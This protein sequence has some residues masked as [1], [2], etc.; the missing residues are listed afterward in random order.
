[1]PGYKKIRYRLTNLS[2]TIIIFLLGLLIYQNS[3]KNEFQFDDTIAINASLKFDSLYSGLPF[4][5]KIN[6]KHRPVS[7][8]ITNFNYSISGKNTISYHIFN[9][10]IH[11]IASLFV[12]LIIQLILNNSNHL[13]EDIKSKGK[14]F[15]LICALL[16]LTHPV[17]TNSVTYII[18]R[19]AS[20]AGMFYL[21]SFY[22]YLKARFRATLIQK[23]SVLYI[24]LA[25]FA[26]LA[27]LFS[28]QNAVTFP[29]AWLLGELFFVRNKQKKLNKT[30]LI[31]AGSLILIIA[32]TVIFANYL[33][34]ETDSF[35]RIEYLLTQTRV[36][37]KYI[38]LA[39]FPISLNI[40]YYFP[41]S[42][43]FSIKELI[44][45]LFLLLV[46]LSGILLYRKHRLISFGIFWFF[47]NLLVTSSII[48]IRD[49]IFEHRLYL[50][51][52]G[53]VLVLVSILSYLF[54]NLPVRYFYL[55][56]GFIILFF[57]IKTILRNVDWKTPYSLWK[58]T[59]SKSPEKARPNLNYGIA[60][61]EKKKLTEA[62]KY[63][64]KSIELD[65]SNP[66]A[67]FNRGNIRYTS[68]NYTGAIQDMKQYLKFYP[69]STASIDIAGKSYMAIKNFDSAI[70]FFNR[71][72]K[73]DSLSKR[74]FFSRGIA[75]Q[76]SGDPDR[77]L[78][79]LLTALKKDNN[80]PVILNK[81]G[82]VYFS[83]KNTIAAL[84]YY[85]K[86]IK[87]DPSFA[88]AY[89]NRAY[90]HST[91]NNINQGIKDFSRTIEINPRYAEAYK[92][93]GLLYYWKGDFINA[94]KDLNKAMSMGLKV[95][96]ALYSEIR[97]K[98]S[99]K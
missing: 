7:K 94:Y 55:I 39:F 37:S 46:L 18:Q 87:H 47:L 27:A 73:A 35:S 50:S 92:G 69:E 62:E 10:I 66:K 99:K 49:V 70:I 3:F 76:A 63:I 58:D 77:A 51:I 52:F 11:I 96:E 38:Q 71:W 34:R 64:S 19:M 75:Y 44:S 41:I 13:R 72:I 43:S 91:Q 98:I 23:K 59:V 15:A 83:S 6:I 33:P 60:C 16:F 17:Q 9:T 54:R 1:M 57:S 48:P 88:K 80:D 97:R 82:E 78:E 14:I 42:E 24:I 30:Y 81:I 12:F 2:A 74:A 56:S 90:L 20:L 5:S 65:S 93:R 25:I 40:D 45:T 61:M 29:L 67:F 95:P 4:W 22:F 28:K 26:G 8:Y 86:A 79:D 21:M 89:F 32:L 84:E 53:A 68:Q 36:I 85:S 31:I